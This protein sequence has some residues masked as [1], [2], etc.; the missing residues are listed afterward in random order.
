MKKISLV[1]PCFNEEENLPEFHRR[2]TEVMKAHPEYDY[3]ILWADNRSTDS[4]RDVIRRICAED[5]HVKAIFNSANFGHIRSPYHA[6][7]AADGDAVVTLCADLQET[8][9][10]IHDF[11]REW[12]NG[13]KVVCGVKSKSRENPLMFFL[14]CC[15]YKI[16][17]TF[18]D[19]PQIE[20]FTGF[21]LYDRVVIGA[22]KR[23]TEPYPYLRGLIAEIGFERVEVFYEQQAR[24]RG[25]SK[26]NLF[27]LY[28]LAM[29]GFVNHTK[30]PL[31][32][33]AFTGFVLAGF[34]LLA[35]LGY[36]VYKLLFW[37][38]FSVGIAPLVIGIF[39]FSSVQLIFIGIIGEYIGAIWTQVKN[40][41]LVIEEERINFEQ[42]GK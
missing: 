27:T 37:D 39:F 40:K 30:L 31:R 20:N 12:E 35:A 28:D 23:F 7:L 32:L 26:N 19:T 34:S 13:A 21:G 36:F 25:K 8:P 24:L 15:Y 16:I 17:K 11:I 22:L 42:E 4:T 29:M 3:E 6:M 9:E 33:A 5:R 41:P 14:R 38:S 18:S 1:S 2:L 10:V